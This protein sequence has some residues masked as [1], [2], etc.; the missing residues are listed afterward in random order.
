MIYYLKILYFSIMEVLYMLLFK[1][2]FIVLFNYIYFNK[3]V[4]KMGF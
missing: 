2:F 1:D 4:K 3:I